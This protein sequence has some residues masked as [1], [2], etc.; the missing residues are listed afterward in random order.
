MQ[1]LEKP[2]KV[3]F[4]ILVLNSKS[5]FL[6]AFRLLISTVSA[7]LLIKKIVFRFE[8][9][10]FSS[11]EG[12]PRFLLFFSVSRNLSVTFVFLRSDFSRFSIFTINFLIQIL[13]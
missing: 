3:F 1:H 5:R 2:E 13:A 4:F 11:I 9:F 8:P 6:F 10:Y 12:P 7:L